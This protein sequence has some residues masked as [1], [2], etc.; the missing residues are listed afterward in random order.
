M[1]RWSAL[2]SATERFRQKV[3]GGVADKQSHRDTQYARDA[4][5]TLDGACAL[6]RARGGRAKEPVLK[7]GTNEVANPFT[8]E[9]AVISV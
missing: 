8:L 9:L 2:A 7:K 3:A 1:A 4:R 5:H 6:P